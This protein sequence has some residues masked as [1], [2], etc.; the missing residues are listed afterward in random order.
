LEDEGKIAREM[1]AV[2]GLMEIDEA[3][4]ALGAQTALRS[5][6]G[7]TTPTNFPQCLLP[8]DE[9]RFPIKMQFLP[10]F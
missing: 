6:H 5:L 2:C 3:R 9:S 1:V 4:G 8:T 7:I 10:L